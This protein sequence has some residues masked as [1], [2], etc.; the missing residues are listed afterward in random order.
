MSR[1]LG[2]TME[3]TCLLENLGVQDLVAT[4][5]VQLIGVQFDARVNCFSLKEVCNRY[6]NELPSNVS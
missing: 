4:V 6:W 3:A 2:L 1:G 5:S